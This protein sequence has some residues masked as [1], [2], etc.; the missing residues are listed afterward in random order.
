MASSIEKYLSD[1]QLEKITTPN[2]V[3]TKLFTNQRHPLRAA[4]AAWIYSFMLHRAELSLKNDWIDPKTNNVYIYFTYDEVKE[5]LHCGTTTCWKIFSMLKKTGLITVKHQGFGNPNQIFIHTPDKKFENVQ[6]NT[7]RPDTN[8]I[9]RYADATENM[10]EN[11]QVAKI[12]DTTV[13]KMSDAADESRVGYIRQVFERF[14]AVNSKKNIENPFGYFMI[15]LQNG[16]AKN[17]QSKPRGKPPN[18]EKDH[19]YDLDLFFNHALKYTPKIKAP[20]REHSYDL[21][22]FDSLATLCTPEIKIPDG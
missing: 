16:K 5:L 15:M 17:T 13:S 9:K 10:F 1:N 14:K 4:A 11:W 18:K 7:Y 3:L 20:E 8:L 22:E 19:S 12:R 6:K 21:N 2:W